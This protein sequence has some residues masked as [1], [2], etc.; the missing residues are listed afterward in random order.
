MLQIAKVLK[1]NGTQGDI[2]LGFKD[3]GIEDIDT[4]EP[5]FINFDGL[6]VPFFIECLQAKG[7]SKA[8]A[9]I[10]GVDNLEDAQEIVGQAVYIDAEVQEDEF[11]DFT[12]WTEFD[13]GKQLGLVSGCEPIPGNLCLYVSTK[14][15]REIL[16]PLHED[17]ILEADVQEKILRT[18]LPEGLY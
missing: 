2:L 13:H 11:E 5:V 18:S 15:N 4:E 7:T 12:G 8:I 1:S 14:T 9:H 16:I 6:P 3:W 17:F 10:T